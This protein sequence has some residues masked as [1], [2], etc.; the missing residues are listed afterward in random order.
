MK[1]RF[2]KDSLNEAYGQKDKV[3]MEDIRTKAAGD[4][5]KEVALAS[6]QARLIGKGEKAAARAEAAVDVFGWDHPV[7]KVFQERAKELGASRGTASQGVLAPV[8]KAAGKGEKLEREFKKKSYLASEK[9]RSADA[10][11][12]GGFQRSGGDGMKSMGIGRFSQPTETSNK[13]EWNDAAIAPIGWVDI[14]TGEARDLNVYKTWPESIAELW[15]TPEGKYRLIFTA[16]EP[17]L[18]IGQTRDFRHSW[19]WKPISKTG[20]WKFIDY[21]PVKDLM[22]L[23]RVY[24]KHKFPGYTY[25]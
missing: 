2:V 10:E 24:N 21:L 19:E 3:R 18:K 15:V 1:A 14:G 16:G 20:S 23:V 17:T 22:E 8:T 7:T 11:K 12:G 5:E 13:H 6:T 25:K 9:I 4:E